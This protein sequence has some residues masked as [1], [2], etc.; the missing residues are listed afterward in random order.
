MEFIWAAD[1]A[2]Y[3]GF[4]AVYVSGT[5][6]DAEYAG[7][8]LLEEVCQA[9]PLPVIGIGGIT[10]ERAASVLARGAAGVAVVSALFQ[11]PDPAEAAKQLLTKL[12][13]AR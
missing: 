8:D 4:G 11:A 1:F 13:T 2:D 3:I 12:R 7:L 9:S 5:K 10:V 6:L